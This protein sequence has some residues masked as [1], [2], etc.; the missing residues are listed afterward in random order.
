MR[1]TAKEYLDL[2]AAH[3]VDATDAQA[4]GVMDRG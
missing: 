4:G 3:R 2:S 1:E